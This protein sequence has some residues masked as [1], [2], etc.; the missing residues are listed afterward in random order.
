MRLVAQRPE[1]KTGKHR[2][3]VDEQGRRTEQARRQ[4]AVLPKAD[5]PQYRRKGQDSDQDNPVALIED[6]AHD[7]Q[8]AAERRRL[9]H[10]KGHDIRQAG[11]QRAKQQ[12]HRR[13]IIEVVAYPGRHRPLLGGVMSAMVVGQLR[14]AGVSQAAGRV[15]ADEIAARRF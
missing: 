12:E 8:K 9:E 10:D 11:E 3:A 6:T 5:C 7:E 4:Q 13:I 15:K 2:P 14:R 1:Q